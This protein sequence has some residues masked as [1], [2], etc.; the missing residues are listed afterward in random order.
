MNIAVNMMMKRKKVKI[1]IKAQILRNK[2]IFKKWRWK[3]FRRIAMMRWKSNNTIPQS[4][5]I[6]QF[7]NK[8]T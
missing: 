6:K 4:Q 1:L 2:K 8:K 3:K 5:K 7:I